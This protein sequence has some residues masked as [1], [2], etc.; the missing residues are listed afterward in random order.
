[1]PALGALTRSRAWAICAGRISQLP[2]A[3]VNIDSPSIIEAYDLKPWEPYDDYGVEDIP[4]AGQP[5]LI[6]TLSYQFRLLTEIVSDTVFMFYAPRER[7][8][9]KKLLDFYSRYTRW[10]NK[11]PEILR[12]GDVPT[13]HL[14]VLQ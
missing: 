11:L 5:I 10:Y 1:M 13:P 4:G 3:A 9:S 7:F 2:R 14:L 6:Q 8:T 12:L